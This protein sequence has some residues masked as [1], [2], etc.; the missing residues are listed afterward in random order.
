M[1]FHPV[2]Q[3]LRQSFRA[4]ASERP[5]ATTAELPGVSI[6]CLGVRFQMFNAAFL[7]GPVENSDVLEARLEA[8]SQYFREAGH[9]WSFWFCDDWLPW[10]VRRRLS[11]VCGPFGL[12]LAAEMP[13]MIAGELTRAS[14]AVPKLEI[15]RVSTVQELGGFRGVGAMCFRVPP[16]WF[17]EVFD[18]RATTRSDFE[19]WIASLNGEP[20]ATAASVSCAGAIGLY[21][22]ATMPEFRGR[23][24]GE[25]VTR[26]VAEDARSR[27]GHLPLVLQATAMG[28][29]LYTRLGFR[30]VTRI[31]A[32]TN[33]R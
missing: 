33:T 1:D 3:N 8:A 10:L 18:S 24:I 20:V 6:V 23:G 4:L 13:G 14:R 22:I 16:D 25:A 28:Q 2:E 19:C 31:L 9:A 15:R 26:F 17:S 7:S 27:H 32:Y 21:N 30:P 12:R 5:G 29:G 11:R